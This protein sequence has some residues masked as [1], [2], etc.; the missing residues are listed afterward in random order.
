MTHAAFDLARLPAALAAHRQ[1]IVYRL[2]ASTTRPGK[3]DK[4]PVDWRSGQ[5]ANAHDSGV[6][7]SAA[8]AAAAAQLWG[9]GHGVGF[10]LTESLGLWFLDIDGALGPDGAWSPVAQQLCSVLTGCYVEVSP[11]GRGLHIVGSGTLPPHGTRC[12]VH[13]LELYHSARFF[14]LTGTGAQGD[15]ATVPRPEVLQ[16]L[17]ESYFPPGADPAQADDWR[18]E[19]VPEWSGPADDD[20]L[21]ARLLRQPVSAAAAFGSGASFRD[22]WEGNADALG[23]AFPSSTGDTW[24]RSSADAALAAHLAWATGRN[25][26]RV[27]RLMERS[28]LRRDKWERA[29]YLPNTVRRMAARTQR[30][31]QDRPAAAVAVGVPAPAGSG[32]LTLLPGTEADLARQF[33]QHAI[34]RMAWSPTFGWLVRD[35]AVWRRDD[36]LKR[37]QAMRRVCEAASLGQSGATL[38]TL[39]KHA[40]V[41]AA[42]NEAASYPQLQIAGSEWDADP[43][44]L[45]TPAGVVDLRTGVLRAHGAA[46]RFM[47]VTAVAPEAIDAPRWRQF[48]AETFGDDVAL[49]EFMQ[50][51]AG[52]WLT[53]DRSAKVFWYLWGVGDT[54]KSV[55]MD[56]LGALLGT[57]AHV[58]AP[59]AIIEQR[60][61]SRHPAD[62]AKLEGKRLAATAELPSGA[63]LNQALLKNLT[64]DSSISAR[65]M[66][67]NPRDVR[68]SHKHVLSSNHKVQLPGGDRALERRLLLVAFRNQVPLPRQDPDLLAKLR[69]EAGGILAWAINGA[70]AWHRDG[71][72]KVGL[73]VPA[74]VDGDSAAYMREEN[75][76]AQWLD[77]CCTLDPL[78]TTKSTD[79]YALSYRPWK[80]QRGGSVESQK[81]WSQRLMATATGVQRYTNNGVWFRGL[82][83][84]PSVPSV[85]PR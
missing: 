37:E 49:I 54:G 40:T 14:T 11:S 48:L 66:G 13:G 19:P 84:N 10:V 56:T 5:V 42:L 12:Q 53:G 15:V 65:G 25:H 64:G 33:V 55:L 47:Q 1:F 45:N 21:V 18:H 57:Y 68:L 82:R 31:M 3:L 8:E 43:M 85:G 32:E 39:G 61:G 23:R 27:R 20:E 2:Q 58:L 81:V 41:R 46:D 83:V 59:D 17:V 69:S 70:V 72:G 73:R 79:A 71:G 52:Y 67:E 78:G 74:A 4:L 60:S 75:D 38:K 63:H 7:T 51:S 22:L 35:G 9:D 6:W 62:L 16:W 36:L 80:S 28:A 24:D 29:D 50:R 30:V 34:G 26:E 76:V 77:E 44:L